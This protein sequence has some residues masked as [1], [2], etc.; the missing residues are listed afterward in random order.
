MIV[1]VMCNTSVFISQEKR[2]VWIKHLIS[3]ELTA[4]LKLKRRRHPSSKFITSSI[5]MKRLTD[6][7]TLPLSAE[8]YRF[9]SASSAYRFAV[10]IFRFL[11]NLPLFNHW[12][13][14]TPSD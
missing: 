10:Q 11:S 9:L 3:Y 14:F 12:V 6:M 2:V 4:L 5:G 7:L 8:V 1:H 13:L